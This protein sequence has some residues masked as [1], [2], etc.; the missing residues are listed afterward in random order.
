MKIP[1]NVKFEEKEEAKNNGAQ[2]DSKN[3]LWYLWDY[4]KL[5]SVNKWMNP[6]YN[7]YVTENIYLVTGYRDCWKCHNSTKVYSIGAE[8]FT[9][10]DDQ[11]K[12]YPV[13]Y[14]I[15]GIELYSNNFIDILKLTN[16]KLK[17]LLS[18]TI[19]LKYLMNTCE[20]CNIPQGDNFIYDEYDAVFSPNDRTEVNNITIKK[21]PLELD[22]GLKGNLFNSYVDGKDTNAMI[23]NGAKHI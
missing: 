21:L 6:D 2:W 8:K 12:F 11:W 10:F 7:I 20:Y 17:L 4:K 14:L 1:L 19:N 13:F 3:K 9:Y 15:N 16:D 22:I 18:K 5:S 23:W